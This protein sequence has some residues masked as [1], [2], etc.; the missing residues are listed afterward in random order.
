M[1]S[2]SNA[3]C[4][5]SILEFDLNKPVMTLHP[6]LQT[7]EHDLAQ[8]SYTSLLT[9]VFFTHRLPRLSVLFQRADENVRKKLGCL[10]RGHKLCL[11]IWQFLEAEN[12]GNVLK[13]MLSYRSVVLKLRLGQPWALLGWWGLTRGSSERRHCQLCWGFK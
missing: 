7:H 10:N 4:S 12:F 13:E 9:S 6:H 3:I 11:D 2:T 5:A 8:K 1:N